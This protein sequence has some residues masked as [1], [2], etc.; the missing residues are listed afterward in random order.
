MTAPLATLL[1]VAAAASTAA[2]AFIYF[3][4]AA[5]TLIFSKVIFPRAGIG[6]VVDTRP[7]RDGQIE[8]EV[9]FSLVS[10]LIFGA[11]GTLTTW[12]VR[13]GCTPVSREFSLVVFLL[14]MV[15][16]FIWNEVHFYIC[17]RLMH[18]RYLF[19]HVHRV[20]HESVTPTPFSTY[21][22]HWVEAILLGS[23][24]VTIMPWHTFSV[25]ALL[26]LPI[27]SLVGN[28]IGHANYELFPKRAAAGA[29]SPCREHGLHH[30]K[31]SGNFGF[32]LPFFDRLFRTNVHSSSSDRSTP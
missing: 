11:Y 6:A 26:S 30:R 12:L 7:L 21:S 31:A 19:A 14:E 13:S 1:P 22:V 23:V 27:I 24:M 2:F 28:S 8:K 4:F 3:G 17:H 5:L 15:A 29:Y 18:T 10:I 16:L 9:K 32:L 25:Y 20:H